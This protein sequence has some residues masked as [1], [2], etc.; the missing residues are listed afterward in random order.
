MFLRCL[1]IVAMMAFCVPAAHAQEDM[2]E[3]TTATQEQSADYPPLAWDQSLVDQVAQA[4]RTEYFPK[5]QMPDGSPVSPETPEEL[6]EPIIPADAQQAVADH[7]VFWVT[8]YWC[9]LNVKNA[10]FE[11]FQNPA[12]WTPKQL[13]YISTLHGVVS[14]LAMQQ[15]TDRGSCP[16]DFKGYLTTNYPETAN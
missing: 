8:A 2:Q 6:Q 16:D 7:A 4:A 5:A 9:G 1:M 12:Q 11:Q 13:T 15:L 14:S 10:N 3:D